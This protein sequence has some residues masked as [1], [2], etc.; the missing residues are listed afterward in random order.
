MQLDSWREYAVPEGTNALEAFA[1]A[2]GQGQPIRLDRCAALIAA[3]EY[4]DFEPAE[5]EGALDRLAAQFSR[6]VGAAGADVELLAH[7]LAGEHAF[8][9]DEDDYYDPD[10]SYI[11][12]V[13]TRRR[14]VPI[15]L[16]IVL[17]EVSRRLG[18][19]VDGIGFPG[20]F[21]ARAELPGGAV[22]HL[23]M[24]NAGVR[25]SQD[26]CLARLQSMYGPNAEL[27]DL[28][29]AAV[30]PRQILARM[31]GNLKAIYARRSDLDRAER[32]IDFLLALS[33]WALDERRDRGVIRQA[34]GNYLGATDDLR[35]YVEYAGDA[36]D[37]DLVRQRLLMLGD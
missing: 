12:R 15:S 1:A 21:L 4:P 26:E 5:V 28:H 18:F 16:T 27:R 24:F 22:A 10:N 37:V 33:P 7:W 2:T 6:R 13:L 25:L 20:H 29:L 8:S 34:R 32:T 36:A 35:V 9:G 31:L 30:T 3:A 11:N 17:M 19:H 14:G 23:D